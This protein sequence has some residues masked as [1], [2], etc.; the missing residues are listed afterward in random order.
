MESLG[1]VAREHRLLV[2]EDCAHAIETLGPGGRHAG[3]YGD[4]AAF[5]FYATENVTTAEGGMVVARNPEFLERIRVLGLHGMSRDAWKR[6]SDEG[7][8]HYEVTELGYK[9]NMSDLHAARGIHH[10][11]RVEWNLKRREEVWRRYHAAFADLPLELPTPVEPGPRHA[12]HL[13]TVLLDEAGAG[14]ERD[15]F[16]AALHAEGIGTG[17]HYLPV[18]HHA[19]YRKRLRVGRREFPRCPSDLES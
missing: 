19:Y 1:A 14:L 12:R 7:Y 16:M 2:V 9:C 18:I 10:V 13:Y 3:T 15:R 11:E 17:V 4:A 5:S 6:Y 8:R